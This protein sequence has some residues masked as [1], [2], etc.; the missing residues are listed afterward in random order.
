MAIRS[1]PSDWYGDWPYPCWPG[2]LGKGYKFA[3][4]DGVGRDLTPFDCGGGGCDVDFDDDAP[5]AVRGSGKF[6][7]GPANASS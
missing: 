4:A 1:V 7:E 5:A 3:E 6:E 2:A